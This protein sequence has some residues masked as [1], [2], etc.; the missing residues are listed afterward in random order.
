MGYVF[1]VAPKTVWISVEDGRVLRCRRVL[2]PVPVGSISLVPT[3]VA[4]C[5]FINVQEPSVPSQ[6]V[7]SV[8]DGEGLLD[9]GND[10]VVELEGRIN[11][12]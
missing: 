9:M 3:L 4:E 7:T 10:E 1:S 11:I 6:E 5:L 12:S 2:R 8:V